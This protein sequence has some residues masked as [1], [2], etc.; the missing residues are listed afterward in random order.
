[1]HPCLMIRLVVFIALACAGTARATPSGPLIAELV[2]YG[3]V[4]A[5]VPA[6]TAAT[7]ARVVAATAEQAAA[8]KLLVDAARTELAR[9]INRHLRTVRDD[10]TFEQIKKSESDVLRGAGM[11]ERQLLVDL[12]AILSAEQQARFAAFERAHRRTLLKKSKPQAMPVDLWKFL[13]SNNVDPASSEQLA[14]VLDKFERESDVALVRQRRALKSYFDNVRQGIDGT[15]E[16]KE[17]DR[18][19]QNELFAANANL[20][21]VFAAVVEPLISV[22]PAELA[23]KLVER[24]IELST[25]DYDRNLA[26][27]SR[28]PIVRE[29]LALS[30]TPE[31]R[32]D[33]E[34]MVEA[35]KSEALT[36]ARTSVIEQARYLLLDDKVRTDGR[37]SPLN[38]YLEKASKLRVRLSAEALAVL[39]PQQRREY[40]AS[41]VLEPS[42][43]STVND[44]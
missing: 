1:M 14:A 18:K 17:R 4:R 27:P 22:L 10:P 19:A 11:I 31:Q 13:A 15:D 28:Y 44:E 38:L 30:L 21:R 41:E 35:A 32:R 3:D 43:S 26:D 20:Q 2:E 40:E 7:F 16:S 34:A 36:L 5:A 8:A 29:V 37:T 42:S 25:E 6:D 33:V 24:I 23:D 39:T 12:S 9:V